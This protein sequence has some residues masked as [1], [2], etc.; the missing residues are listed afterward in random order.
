[1]KAAS[2]SIVFLALI[3]AGATHAGALASTNDILSAGPLLVDDASISVRC[4]LTLGGGFDAKTDAMRGEVALSP[5]QPG[6]VDGELSVDLSTLQTGIALRDE[7]MREK[8]LEVGKGPAFEAA[9]LADIRLEG[10][11][12]NPVGK[13]RFRGMLTLH[14]QTREVTGTAAIR[15]GSKGLQVQANFPVKVSAF[16]IPTPS[17]LG[18]GVR[19]EVSVTVNFSLQPK[20][21]I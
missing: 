21:S 4:P 12:A 6:M 16:A 18:V 1:M 3:V 13:A 15:Q 5:S 20:R 19:D 8:Y 2:W 11:E 9:K 7:H 14:G 17:Y 10:T